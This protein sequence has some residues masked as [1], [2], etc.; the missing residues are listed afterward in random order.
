MVLV[1][2]GFLQFGRGE[3]IHMFQI[4]QV[5]K[6]DREIYAHR[7]D[8]IETLEQ[9]IDCCEKYFYRLLE[10]E[11]MR[12]TLEKLEDSLLEGVT[13]TCYREWFRDSLKGII[14]FHDLGKVN[15]LF[16]KNKM[17]NNA[18]MR[19]EIFKNFLSIR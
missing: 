9:H 3:M 1:Y 4:A 10:K 8:K 13:E 16:Q 15:P 14:T 12:E 18:L 17:K 6:K 7:T 5:L 2:C 11:K 19:C